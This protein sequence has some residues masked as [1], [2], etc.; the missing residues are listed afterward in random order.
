[1]ECFR[2]DLLTAPGTR[3]REPPGARPSSGLRVDGDGVTLSAL[4]RRGDR[5]ELRLAAQHP[6]P[7][8]A[9]VT[10]AGLVA[11]READL[12]GRAGADLPVA[13]DRLRL[14]L[15]AWEIRTVQL[16]L[17]PHSMSRAAGAPRA[18]RE[19]PP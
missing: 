8:T 15:A 12:L 9:T 6:V 4:R 16:Q 3:D 10:V 17:A 7:T 13:G 19:S 2:H 5:L 11:A 1:M 14:D 18:G